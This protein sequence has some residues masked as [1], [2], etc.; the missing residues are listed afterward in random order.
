MQK[1][2]Q[3]ISIIIVSILLL[4]LN[5]SAN[6]TTTQNDFKVIVDG[7]PVAIKSGQPQDD[8]LIQV[9]NKFYLPTTMLS[10]WNGKIMVWDTQTNTMVFTTPTPTQPTLAPDL[11]DLIV[12][13]KSLCN[14]LGYEEYAAKPLSDL[15]GKRYKITG[16]IMSIAPTDEETVVAIDPYDTSDGWIL[17][18]WRN[19]SIQNQIK[20]GN[21]ISI[22]GVIDDSVKPNYPEASNESEK[23]ALPVLTVK[24]HEFTNPE[25]QAI[26]TAQGHVWTNASC[27]APKTCNICKATEGDAKAHLLNA[28]KRCIY[29]NTVIST[30]TTVET[31]K[32]K[33]YKPN[34]KWVVDGEW[35]FTIHSVKTHTK[36][37]KFNDGAGYDQIITIT[38]SY[39]N[40]GYDRYNFMGLE[41]DFTDMDV[42]DKNN[43]IGTNY[44][45]I[46][47]K[48][49]QDVNIGKQCSNAQETFAIVTKSKE[50][51]IEV[52]QEAD[53]Q[54]PPYTATFVIPVK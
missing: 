18:R 2:L 28:S 26:C 33:V 25:L 17:V 5:L 10:Q 16:V 15:L 49:P 39:K 27:S 47:C 4:I 19:A 24:Y 21:A 40:L 12:E 43:E 23:I 42:Y 3:N 53:G 44:T 50:I 8:I 22:W 52:S 38:Y 11:T 13:Y 14:N 54:T 48:D 37:N 7:Q 34:E 51:T 36:C 41:F 30:S 31:N 32:P 45:C 6:N 1:A 46:H 9:S 20:V 35:E 29:C